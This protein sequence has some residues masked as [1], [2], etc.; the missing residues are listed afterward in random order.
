MLQKTIDDC[1]CVS[2]MTFIAG[3]FNSKLG[4]RLDPSERFMGN[5]GKGT[6]NRNGHLLANFLAERDFF[7]ANT[8]FKH[9][10]RH[11]STWHGYIQNAHR[12]NQIDYILIP[13]NAIHQPSFL[14][15]R[16]KRNLQL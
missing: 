7:A 2:Y 8:A 15:N 6:R 13:M 1:E 16:T 11:R 12:Y 4:L 5:Y 3:D 9:H 14:R 10:M